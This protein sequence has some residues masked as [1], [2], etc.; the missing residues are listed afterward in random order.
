MKPPLALKHLGYVM[1]CEVTMCLG[2]WISVLY[3]TSNW[4]I[5]VIR[6]THVNTFGRVE[7]KKNEFPKY[8]L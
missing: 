8:K 6:E 3:V 7:F 4:T 2:D 5:T 1:S